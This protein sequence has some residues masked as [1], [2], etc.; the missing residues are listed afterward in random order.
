MQNESATKPEIP[1]EN[2]I[3]RQSIYFAETLKLSVPL[4]ISNLLSILVTFIGVLMLGNLGKTELA[5]SALI[6]SSQST[7]FVICMGLLFSISVMVGRAHG[8]K[9][10]FEIG[11]VAQ[12]GYLLALLLAIPIFTIFWNIGYILALFKQPPELISYVSTYF[13]AFSWG[14]P[15]MV[16]NVTSVQFLMGYGKRTPILIISLSNL[17]LITTIGGI[18]IYGKLGLPKLGIAGLGYG[19]VIQSWTMFVSVIIYFLIKKEFHSCELFK[20]RIFKTFAI[21]K[22]LLQ[23]GWPIC[24]QMASELL[25]FFAV[26][27]MAGWINADALA[28]RQ[29]SVQYTLL[30][31]LPLMAISQASGVLVSRSMGAKR[32]Q[33]VQHYGNYALL[34][35]LIISCI[36][37]LIFLIFPHK[38]VLL[39]IHTDATDTSNIAHLS[40]ILLMIAAGGQIIDGIRNVATGALRGLYDTQFPMKISLLSLWVIGIPLAYIMA[41]PLHWGIIGLSLA[42]NVSVVIGAITLYLRWR[43]KCAALLKGVY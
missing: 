20:I 22:K 25:T 34:L 8:A 35:G 26:T 31:I 39:F 15:A 16:F 43:H 11:S 12:Q 18:L 1:Y 38:L 30:M 29:V 40:I 9:N 4:I 5:S 28:A 17:L 21:L 3:K 10:Y 19:Y 7:V 23:I 6:T 36:T 2:A 42:F 14:I 24:L 27:I 13:R 41:F 37:C 33:D 32:P